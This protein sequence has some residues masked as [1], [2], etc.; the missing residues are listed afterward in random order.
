MYLVSSTEDWFQ[1]VPGVQQA[2]IGAGTFCGCASSPDPRRRTIADVGLVLSLTGVLM[3]SFLFLSGQAVHDV[4]QK[5]KCPQEM[6]CP[7]GETRAPGYRPVRGQPGKCRARVVHPPP[8]NAISGELLWAE[9]AS[10]E[11]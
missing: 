4:N 2:G 8:A 1:C 7:E 9:E 10:G 11:Q 3:L 5:G 6:G